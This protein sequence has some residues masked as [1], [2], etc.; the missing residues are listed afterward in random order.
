MCCASHVS[1]VKAGVLVH[2]ACCVLVKL[3]EIFELPPS[4]SVA[5][6]AA[7]VC[8]SFLLPPSRFSFLLPRL[9]QFLAA[10][11]C[12]GRVSC[13]PRL[14]QFLAAPVCFSFLLPSS[15][16]VSCCPRLF[17]FLAAPVCFSFSLPPSVSVSCCPSH[18]VPSYPRLFRSGLCA[19]LVFVVRLLKCCRLG[20]QASW[21]MKF[22][23]L[24]PKNG[25]N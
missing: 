23:L 20:T 5:S 15:V 19:A 16:S 13:C 8:F 21:R 6:L 22:I 24:G 4:V 25:V 17:Q 10:P 14:F 9:F 11:V 12:F 2:Q 18:R 7:P 3:S 1:P